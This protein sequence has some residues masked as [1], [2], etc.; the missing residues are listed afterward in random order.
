[1]A[2]RNECGKARRGD[3]VETGMTLTMITRPAVSVLQTPQR[4]GTGDRARLCD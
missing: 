1:M 4:L 2:A 3:A